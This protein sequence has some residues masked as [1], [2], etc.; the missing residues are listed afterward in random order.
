M[1][2]P[3]APVAPVAPVAPSGKHMSANG[4][5]AS[6]VRG[7]RKKWRLQIV[8]VG[9]DSIT[10]VRL[11]SGRVVRVVVSPAT[12]L[13]RGGER[14]SLWGQLSALTEGDVIELTLHGG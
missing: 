7:K 8:S 13:E 5:A 4:H 6:A 2:L 9:A 10:G 3:L 12:T 11:K 1:C 14:R